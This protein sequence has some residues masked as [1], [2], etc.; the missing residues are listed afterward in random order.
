MKNLKNHLLVI[1]SVMLLIFNACSKEDGPEEDIPGLPIITGFGEPIG[2]ADEVTI[3]PEG[4]TI[5]SSDGLLS[6]SIPQGA[7]IRFNCYK[8]STHHKPGTAWIGKWVSSWTGRFK[9]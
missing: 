4:G 1:A 7:L 3:G 2:Q 9:L 6:V 8:Y 5:N